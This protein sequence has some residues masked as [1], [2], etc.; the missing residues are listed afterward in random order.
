VAEGE[1]KLNVW[2]RGKLRNEGGGA[3]KKRFV[4]KKKG[5]VSWT[6]TLQDQEQDA[7]KILRIPKNNWRPKGG[8]GGCRGP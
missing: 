7:Q 3:E 5:G 1:K 6:S 8:G 4:Q 2:G